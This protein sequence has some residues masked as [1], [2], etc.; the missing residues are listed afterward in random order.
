VVQLRQDNA[1][2]TLWNMVGFQTKL[3]HAAQ[4]EV[5]RTIPGLNGAV[6]ARLG[7]LHRNTFINSPKVLDGNLRLRTDPRLRFAGQITGVEGYVESAAVGLL[8]GRM[9]AADWA[10]AP[11]AAPPATTAL[12]ALIGHITGGHLAAGTRSFQPMNINYGL[13]PP[14]EALRRGADGQRFARGERGRAKK[15]AMSVRALADLESWRGGWP[16]TAAPSLP[17]TAGEAASG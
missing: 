12:G 6:F 3:K 5:F 15:R 1:L 2:G 8:A 9:A 4:T 11:F 7:G 14:M 13:L 16:A 10:G 17:P